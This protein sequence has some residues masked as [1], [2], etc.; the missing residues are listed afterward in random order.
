MLIRNLQEDLQD[1]QLMASLDAPASSPKSGAAN[2]STGLVAANAAID[3]GQS[4]EEVALA[5]AEAAVEA[6]ASEQEVAKAAGKA[7]G[8]AVHA[9]GGHIL[10]SRVCLHHRQGGHPVVWGPAVRGHP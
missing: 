7:A 2:R 4:V 8:V 1:M 9:N 6:D 10:F 3:Q 5:A